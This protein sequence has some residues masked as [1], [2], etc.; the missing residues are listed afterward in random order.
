M[1]IMLNPNLDKWK[2]LKMG[3]RTTEYKVMWLI[4]KMKITT[5]NNSEK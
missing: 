4:V 2:I 5:N 1:K 3:I